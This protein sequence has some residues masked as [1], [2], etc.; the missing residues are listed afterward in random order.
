MRRAILINRSISASEVNEISE[1]LNSGNEW[2]AFSTSPHESLSLNFQPLEQDPDIKRRINVEEMNALLGFGETIHEGITISEN[3][4]INGMSLWH[5]H[6]FRIYFIMRNL[7]YEIELI[8]DLLSR[9][10]QVICYSSGPDTAMLQ[11][12]NGQVEFRF[13]AK[14]QSKTG[15]FWSKLS[16]ALVVFA[17]FLSGFFHSFNNPESIHLLIDRAT[18]QPCLNIKTLRPEPEN[19]NLAYVFAKANKEFLIIDEIEQPKFSGGQKFAIKKW[20]L[21]NPRKN[22]KRIFGEYILLRAAMSPEIW[23]IFRHADREIRHKLLSL[24]DGSIT[25]KEIW[26]VKRMLDFHKASRF[27]LFKNLAWKRFFK[28]GN[29]KSISTIDENSPAVKAILDA[30]KSNQIRT[31][32]IQHGNIHEL[33][34]AYRFTANDINRNLICDSTIVWGDYWKEFLRNISGYPSDRLFTAGQSRTDIIPL[35]LER[36]E[37][38]TKQLGLP[39]KDIVVFASQ[40]QQDPSLRERAAFD[41][42]NAVKEIK[43]LHLVVKL[44]P[45][46]AGYPEFYHRIAKIAGCKNYTVTSG[47][48]LYQLIAACKIVITCFST[49]GSEAI[50]FNK[51][52][53]ILDHLEQ[54]IQGYISQGVAFKAVG[55]K[56]MEVLIIKILTNELTPDEN[57]TKKFIRRNAFSIDGNTSERI[58]DFIRYNL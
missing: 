56:E 40:L 42:F 50:Y 6:K 24:L 47:M 20:M 35:L 45:S 21:I 10:E 4:T 46:E 9:F 33:H 3:L 53:I 12:I 41:V 44:H 1:T 7:T 13:S 49:V 57:A 31:I 58:I 2:T 38:L 15:S 23:K 18:K 8:K 36:R 29:F 54:D 5:Y 55:S 51:P 48:D 37:I 25:E 11:K 17:R 30:A 16:Y 52:L 19:Y 34:P 39:G 14:S 27:Y 32:G 26:M 22:L 28:F 43:N